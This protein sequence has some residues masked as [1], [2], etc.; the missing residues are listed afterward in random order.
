M[1]WM[2]PASILAHSG[3][4]DAGHQVEGEDALGALFVA[5]DGEGDAL[6][7]EDDRFVL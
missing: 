5:V 4:D 2:R 1:R 6:A 3:G 7:E